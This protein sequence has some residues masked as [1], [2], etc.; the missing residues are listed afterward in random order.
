MR[1]LRKRATDR[2]ATC[3]CALPLPL[4]PCLN[5]AGA[6]AQKRRDGKNKRESSRSRSIEIGAGAHS[7]RWHV[8]LLWKWSV[9]VLRS[10]LKINFPFI[11]VIDGLY[12]TL[13]NTWEHECTMRH[14]G[15]NWLQVLRASGYTLHMQKPIL[16]PEPP[17]TIPFQTREWHSIPYTIPFQTWERHTIL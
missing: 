8:F 10:N 5:A 11:F 14:N 6:P 7:A 17:H 3:S 13:L 15:S 16:I 9:H 2:R 4:P 12:K 1:Y